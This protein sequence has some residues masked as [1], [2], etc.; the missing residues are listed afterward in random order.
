MDEEKRLVI[1]FNNGTNLEVAFPVQIRDSTAGVLEAFKRI[2]DADKL[3]IHAEDRLL[4]IP[5]PSVKYVELIPPP[6]TVPFG[7]VQKA[8]IVGR[9]ED[10]NPR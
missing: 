4:I 3:A 10:V 6:L 9:T 5:W 7:T 8:R 1:H 2:L